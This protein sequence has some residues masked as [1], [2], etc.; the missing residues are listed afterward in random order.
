MAYS[1]R[2]GLQSNRGDQ[3]RFARE[4]FISPDYHL[5]G[6]LEVEALS[7]TR[8]VHK[9]GETRP[10]IP[11]RGKDLPYLGCPPSGPPQHPA[12][13]SS[14]PT[15]LPPLCSQRPQ[16]VRNSGGHIEKNPLNWASSCQG[17]WAPPGT[18]PLGHLT[19]VWRSQN[20]S[21]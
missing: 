4:T 15:P 18:L 1:P 2:G 7:E 17:G 21:A 10:S 8:Q 19:N 14:P 12:W 5:R 9:C 16:G 13:A 3:I 11:Q 6:T 20:Y